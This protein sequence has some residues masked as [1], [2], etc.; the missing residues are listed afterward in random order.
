M[1]GHDVDEDAVSISK[2]GGKWDNGNW[3]GITFRDLYDSPTVSGDWVA[4]LKNKN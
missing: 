4:S 3:V 2:C 1:A